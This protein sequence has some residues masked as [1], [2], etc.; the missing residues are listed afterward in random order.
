[1]FC[2]SFVFQLVHFSSYKASC[3]WNEL[4][5]LLWKYLIWLLL[6]KNLK[7][8]FPC[9]TSAPP[10]CQNVI[11]L[12][13]IIFLNVGKTLSYLGIFVLEFGKTIVIFEINTLEFLKNEPLSQTV[14]FCIGSAFSRGPGSDFLKVQVRVRVRFI[15]YACEIL[16]LSRINKNH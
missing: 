14:N 13:K 11:F 3:K 4:Q 16:A 7:K 8:L 1:M 5:I 2:S 10:V 6:G 15:K 12:V 9:L